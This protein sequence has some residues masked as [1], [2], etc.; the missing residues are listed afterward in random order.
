[1]F[2]SFHQSI[3]IDN[4]GAPIS[5]AL[6]VRHPDTSHAAGTEST[7]DAIARYL[8]YLGTTL[9]LPPEPNAS[10]APANI[11]TATPARRAER[12]E[13]DCVEL[14][15]IVSAGVGHSIA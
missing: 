15:S 11:L 2:S 10:A 12:H 9:G 7:D 14:E 4:T 5:V 13:L 1:M 8:E 3:K 6:T